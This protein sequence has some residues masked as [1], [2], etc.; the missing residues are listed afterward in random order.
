MIR[1]SF[2]R[3]ES[4]EQ[5]MM[6][7]WDMPG[8]NSQNIGFS[9]CSDSG[10][11][12]QSPCPTASEIFEYY[13]E[14]ATYI[15]PG[16]DGKPS[17]DK[18]ADLTRLIN[19]VS[20]VIGYIP[21]NI[22]QV[23]CSDGYTLNRFK[24]AG[25]ADV[26]GIDPSNASH[27]LAKE[28]YQIN[29]HIG[30]IEEYQA[31]TQKHDL[32]ILTHVLE[33][34]FN[35]IDTL[36]QCNEMQIEGH[37]ILVEVPLF[38][39]SDLF[40]PGLLTLEHLNYFSEGTIIESITRSGYDPLFIGKYFNQNEYPVITVV[41][42]KNENIQT[43]ESSAYTT[44]KYLLENYIEKEKQA[45]S[46]IELNIS[47]QVQA[48]S[49]T[50]IFGAGFHTSQILAFTR[51]KQYLDIVGLLDSSPTKWGKK[52]GDLKCYNPLSVNFEKGDVIIISSFASEE[53]IYMSLL[54]LEKG[55]IQIVRLYG[56]QR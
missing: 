30:S 11:I 23:G 42:Q 2:L 55:G 37:W 24:Q 45:W 48:G 21:N 50:Y 43:I 3:D 41:A 15:N 31:S 36:L 29:T 27:K 35:P 20:S 47:S 19:V 46:T 40:P 51:L 22:F 12:I 34:L 44:S 6:Q 49:S 18:I 33:H 14:T 54:E 16:R 17:P 53:E 13:T 38:E 8:M 25:A 10:L 26:S 32:I 39:R 4:A 28:L 52:M 1:K 5:V 56:E 7:E 9:I